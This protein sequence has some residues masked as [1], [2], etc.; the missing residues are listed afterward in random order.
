MLRHFQSWDL[1]AILVLTTWHL[2]FFLPITLGQKFFA[3]D[4]I[5]SLF[6]PSAIALSRAYSEGTIP[7]WVTQIQSGFP[8]FAEGQVAAL[9]PV[10]F[11]FYHLFSPYLAISYSILFRLVWMSIGIYLF[12]RS[13]GLRT[14]SALLSGF[15]FGF[16]GFMLAQVQHL[17]FQAVVSWL[18]WALYF[19][20]KMLRL[21]HRHNKRWVTWWFFSALAIAF[22]F[23]GGYPQGAI[24]SLIP[25]TLI[26]LF[27]QVTARGDE[28]Q[29]RSRAIESAMLSLGPVALG[30]GIAAVQI[31]PTIELWDLSDRGLELG[32][33]FFTTNSLKPE[34]L[35]QFIAPYSVLGEPAVSNMEYFGYIGVIPMLLTFAS[36][37]RRDA[38]VIFFALL[39]VGALALALG[40]S[41]PLYPALYI[42][43]IFNRF[44]VPAR[45]LLVF[46]LAAV[47]LAAMGF[48]EIVNRLTV[49][50]WRWAR[51]V[52]VAIVFVLAL[53]DLAT[54]A[55]PFLTTLDRMV[56]L[57][58][59]V[60]APRPITLM[61]QSGPP[62]RI[63][64][65][66]YNESLRPNH[67]L[68]FDKESPQ[69]YT[70]LAIRRNEEYLAGMSSPMLN[71]QNVRYYLR[72]SDTE[73]D[74]TFPFEL[75]LFQSRVEIPTTRIASL[76]VTSYTDKTQDASDGTL[77]GE[78]ILVLR[79]GSELKFPLRVGIET[80]DWAFEALDAVK[81]TKPLQSTLFPAYLPSLGHDFT[82][83]KYLARIR[84]GSPQVI[85]V[86]AES[87]LSSGKLTVE[88][89]LLTD[90]IGRTIS[91]T[92]LTHKND[93]SLVFKSHSV[94]MF[95]NR[96]VMPRAFLVHS[97]Q[98][99]S[100]E[101]AI[102]R[103]RDPSFDP[104]R[105][106]FLADGETM[107]DMHGN[108]E[109][110][111]RVEISQR[112]SYRVTINME[113]A[114]SGYLVLTDSW[115]PGW[116]AAVDSQKVEIYRA[117]YVFRAIKV[118]PGSHTIVFEFH[119]GSILLGSGIS[120]ISTLIGGILVLT[121]YWTK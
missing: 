58:E 54:F 120:V 27:T 53:A 107:E 12:C 121:R 114:R 40:S 49:L 24:L 115:Y 44:R 99:V 47:Y 50:R 42:L 113:T 109:Q 48:E 11:V 33:G 34:M 65:M 102:A 116:D 97:A 37:L 71:L 46:L 117:N 80:G 78:I 45:F 70:G 25:F 3:G 74:D 10:N 60:Q 26:S 14:T 81:H 30:I 87:R 64:T 111:D 28:N 93:L 22:Q 57:G 101:Q 56:P 61:A 43:P 32:L 110:N 84:V 94:A 96:D 6:L 77:A 5:T 82:G 118:S 16:N 119:P 88:Q 69:I 79:D 23:L 83:R 2:I 95:E 36:F 75:N 103:M 105:V 67:P 85:A 52:I 62:Y 15:V 72:V 59:I 66:I 13:S 68:I 41:T 39:A 76:L 112:D 91:L 9:E 20:D 4:D 92:A 63:F 8:L 51:G 86:R 89:V 21:W 55:Q 35:S 100:D 90:D 19:Q 29:S 7:L 31:V 18:P 17:A 1:P 73:P 98:I 108:D 106:A 104:R 38:R